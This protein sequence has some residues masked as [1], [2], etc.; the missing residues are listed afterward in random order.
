MA[1]K[2][3]MADQ[4]STVQRV[5]LADAHCHLDLFEGNGIAMEAL[6]YGVNIIVTNGV[7]TMSNIKTLSISDGRHVFPAL[8]I[9]PQ[10][11][12]SMM[13]D[14]VEFNLNMIRSNSDRIV[15]IGEVGLDYVISESPAQLTRQHK[16]FEKMIDIALELGKPLSIHSRSAIGDVLDILEEKGVKSA[17]LHFFEGDEEHAA[18]INELGYMVSVPPQ[19][20]AKRSRALK[21]IDLSSIMA[22][23]DSPAAGSSPKSVEE[24]IRIIA[25][26]KG[27]GYD[28]AAAL[29]T[30]NTKRFFKIGG[31]IGIRKI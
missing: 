5:E 14:E 1:M 21:I 8:G 3:V 24:S 10:H 25:D 6:G 15:A 22:E 29:T 27:M 20:S 26:I 31:T 16:I 4:T 2:T 17:H 30:A 28:E 19:K 23:S 13:D 18:R 7:D 9:D 11:A 12:V